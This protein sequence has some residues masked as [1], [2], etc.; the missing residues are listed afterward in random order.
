MNMLMLSITWRDASRGDYVCSS[1]ADVRGEHV[2]RFSEVKTTGQHQP[3]SPLLE[4]V[5][6]TFADKKINHL[7]LLLFPLL[8]KEWTG[9]TIW[10]RIKS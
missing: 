7:A 5:V 10:R 1:W 9:C 4:K 2:A 8:F 3:V 6:I